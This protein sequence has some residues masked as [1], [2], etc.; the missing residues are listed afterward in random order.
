[1]VGRTE[2]RFGFVVLILKVK[3]WSVELEARSSCKAAL[4][5]ANGN[6]RFDG[7][8][9]TLEFGGSVDG[10][11]EPFE[12]GLPCRLRGLSH[13]NMDGMANRSSTTST[14]AH[15]DASLTRGRSS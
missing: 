4:P 9:C 3:A 15:T 14:R 7:R 11:D 12:P 5:T 10:D 2:Y 6:V 8:H 13:P 1:M